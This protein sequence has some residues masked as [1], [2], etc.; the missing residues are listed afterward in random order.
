LRGFIFVVMERM[1]SQPRSGIYQLKSKT[2]GKIYIGSS[3]NIKGRIYEHLNQLKK[4]KHDNKYLQN[5]IN[6]Y[7]ID[8]LEISVVEYCSI[9]K[10]LER[11]QFHMDNLNAEF[12]LVPAVGSPKRIY[13]E[14]LLIELKGPAVDQYDTKGN[15]IR[16]FNYTENAAC[17]M[18]IHRVHINACI[19]GRLIEVGGFLWTLKGFP[20]QPRIDALNYDYP[21]YATPMLFNQYT[22]RGKYIQSFY[23]VKEA[24]TALGIKARLIS[25]CI[26]GKRYYAGE[27][28]FSINNPTK[29][30]IHRAM[31]F[32][33]RY[34]RSKYYQAK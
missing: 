4:L 16:S 19:D 26:S 13:F 21:L 34:V 31:E 14:Q 27:Y 10:L 8:D 32:S 24:A 18:G 25:E 23:S 29:R 33:E 12:N 22:I 2:N 1:K 5:H 6:K 11:E 28:I 9:S 3:R 15:F 7:G 30:S 17:Y 20:I